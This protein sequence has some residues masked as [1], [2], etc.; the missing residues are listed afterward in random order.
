MQVSY[1]SVFIV[2]FQCAP[3]IHSLSALTD[4]AKYDTYMEM[5]PEEEEN[6]EMGS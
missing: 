2:V 3:F 1:M 4:C 6:G 5:Q